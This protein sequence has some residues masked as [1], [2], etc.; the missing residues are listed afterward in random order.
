MAL[1]SNN[2]YSYLPIFLL[3]IGVLLRL[4]GFSDWS[5]HNDELS[6]L[7]RASY[8]SFR[9]VIEKGVKTDVH[10]AFSE[11]MVHYCIQLFGSSPLSLRFP[12]LLSS[13]FG[14]FYFYKLA[15]LWMNEKAANLALAVL[16]FSYLFVLY[17][18]IARPYAIGFLF[19]TAF[20]YYWYSWWFGKKTTNK[21]ILSILFGTLGIYT[22]YFLGLSIAL[23]IASSLF[24][25]PRTKKDWLFLFLVP[26]AMGLLFLPHLEITMGHLSQKGVGWLPM[27]KDDFLIDFIFFSFNKSW[28]WIS[29]IALSPLSLFIGKNEK[30]LHFKNL[31]LL[32]L[33]A[34]PY[35]I[36]HY[37]S[38]KVSPVLQYSVLI[39][40]L[41]FLLLF[42]FSF[43]NEHFPKKIYYLYLGLIILG[44]GYSLVANTKIYEKKPFANFK[45]VTY[46]LANWK[47]NYGDKIKLITNTNNV[48]YLNYYFDE[49]GIGK[50]KIAISQFQDKDDYLKVQ[51]LLDTNNI[52]YIALGFANV[53]IPLEVHEL[54]KENFTEIKEK[55][56]YF[57][58]EAILYKRSILQRESSMQK[59]FEKGNREK[60]NVKIKYFQ[61]S[62]YYSAP[63]AYLL[64]SDQLYALSFKGEV[65]DLFQ[66]DKGE[67]LTASAKVFGLEEESNL[68]AVV[69]I[70]RDKETIFWGSEELSHFAR[71]NKWSS[72]AFVIE[73]KKEYLPN[74]KIAIYFWNPNK[75]SLVVDDFKLNVYNDSEY[76]YYDF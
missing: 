25:L 64:D 4:I 6:T 41:P 33:F 17:G 71:R 66:K 16:S 75:S 1:K 46:Y 74:D 13:I 8:Q 20:S 50:P 10:P 70:S 21:V 40:S 7:F 60:W 37:Y 69:S 58:S 48:E 5:L 43:F 49:N 24:F 53:A 76:Y 14:L 47:N 73:K 9:E 59:D 45:E 27:P 30:Q 61:D 57:N 31:A 26:L 54:V 34:I 62:I 67:W 44:G 72:M 56:R 22:H 32:L 35:G 11:I 15:K 38:I 52:E 68:K 28:L 3:S 55:R 18:Q 65:Q 51:E 29:L 36:G 12:Y 63:N 39:Y 2:I 23:V 19:I 42:V